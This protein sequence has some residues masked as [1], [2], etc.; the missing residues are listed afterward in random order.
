MMSPEEIQ[1]KYP[2]IDPA[3]AQSLSNAAGYQA[4]TIT[5]PTQEIVSG[6]QPTITLPTQEITA[7][8]SVFDRA[9]AY[10]KEKAGQAKGFAG[11]A[12]D[13]AKEHPELVAS[14]AGSVSPIAGA[15]ALGA[16]A[17]AK[18]LGRA[19]LGEEKPAGELGPA[20][21]EQVSTPQKAM[22]PAE[23]QSLMIGGRVGGGAVGPGMSDATSLK[24][25]EKGSGQ[26]N[27]S[28]PT[29][30]AKD[31]AEQQIDQSLL[32]EENIRSEAAANAGQLLSD[33]ANKVQAREDKLRNDQIARQQA[34]NELQ[35]KIA[36]ANASADAMREGD[37]Y[38][39]GGKDVGTSAMGA[40]SIIFGGLAQAHGAKE[41]MG[42]NLV[43][44]QIDR[45]IAAQRENYQRAKDKGQRLQGLYAELRQQGF[46]DDA[47]AA[48][49]KQSMLD[50][51]QQRLAAEAANADS[52]L[53]R[54]NI[55]RAR[56][57]I[58]LLSAQAKEQTEAGLGAMAFQIQS[59]YNAA[60][61]QAANQSQTG[62]EYEGV[63]EKALYHLGGN[64]FIKTNSEKSAEKIKERAALTEN[65]IAAMNQ[66][67]ALDKKIVADPI[68]GVK[69]LQQRN[70]L[71]DKL[72]Y[73]TSTGLGQ[74]I[75]HE[76]EVGRTRAMAG[77][78][79]MAQLLTMHGAGG[80]NIEANYTR[81]RNNAQ[82][83]LNSFVNKEGG[84]M[85]TRR[86]VPTKTGGFRSA[87]FIL[88]G[89]NPYEAPTIGGQ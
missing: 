72:M 36:K 78:M 3:Q 66:L 15:T 54:A 21:P 30:I 47:A 42:L 17:G 59:R 16:P 81:A 19:V 87:Y 82:S 43:Q 20:G 84:V 8:P 60:Q 31:N 56:G 58:A 37:A 13:F 48:A 32:Q 18:A 11:R 75:V 63:D 71:A 50:V 79:T 27:I 64:T 83:D 23:Q 7:E 49:A 4:P 1:A 74:G 76:N 2:S 57:Q 39:F 34:M 22:S 69:L 73:Q 40:L 26:S 14:T 29:K 45:N 80:K 53:A 67:E 70:M 55:E 28:L 61:A 46:D 33:V 44:R 9:K 88:Q 52:G 25:A 5:L 38:P 6:A 65:Q 86:F 51:T 85:L 77:P 41:N 89:G 12:I 35:A 24:L 68:K 62:G 10:V